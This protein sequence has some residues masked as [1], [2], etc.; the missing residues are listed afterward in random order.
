MR[1]I[2]LSRDYIPL[3]YCDIKRAMT[4]VYLK[5]AEIIKES[6]QFLRSVSERFPVPKVIRLLSKLIRH[7]TPRVTYS[8]KNVQIRDQFR[9]QY[10]GSGDNLTLDHVLPVSRGGP[11]TWENVVTAC[12]PCNARKGSCTPEEA[13]MQLARPPVRPSM[14]VQID[15]DQLFGDTLGAP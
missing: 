10:C 7:L 11:S 3:M 12:Y 2:V 1:V 15:W 5:K 14:L 4:L 6:G 13:G 8:R 9:C